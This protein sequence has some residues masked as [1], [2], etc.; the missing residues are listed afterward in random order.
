MMTDKTGKALLLAA[1]LVVSRSGGITIENQVVF[2]SLF[3]AIWLALV[4][5]SN[6]DTNNK[7]LGYS[8]AKG[9]LSVI[10][11]SFIVTVC[12]T[13]LILLSTILCSLAIELANS[14]WGY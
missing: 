3:V 8:K 6:A 13:I 14:E 10:A 11:N 4:I 7:M 9:I 1:E 5:S 12:I 2:I